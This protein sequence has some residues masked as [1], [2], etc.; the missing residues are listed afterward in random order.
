MTGEGALI[1]ALS[2][3]LVSRALRYDAVYHLGFGIARPPTFIQRGRNGKG[4]QNALPRIARDVSYAVHWSEDSF[5]WSRTVHTFAQIRTQLY[6]GREPRDQVRHCHP[7][8]ASS[9]AQ[10]GTLWA[11]WHAVDNINDRCT[12]ISHE[13]LVAQFHMQLLL[14][15]A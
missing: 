14:R 6:L 2:K 8:S 4:K 15:T 1:S 10:G 7:V 13:T 9:I 11:H 3:V 5:K 12:N